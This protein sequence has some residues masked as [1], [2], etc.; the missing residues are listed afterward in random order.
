MAAEWGQ[1]IGQRA[2]KPKGRRGPRVPIPPI[3]TA[4]LR[5]R[6]ERLG[7][8]VKTLGRS[9]PPPGHPL[10]DA[11]PYSDVRVKTD[12]STSVLE[13]RPRA[14]GA[15]PRR[16][17]RADVAAP[18][19]ARHARR[20]DARHRRRGQPERAQQS[21]NRGVKQGTIVGKDGLERR[22]RPLPARPR[23]RAARAG[24]RLRAPI[25]NDRLRERDPVRR[26]AAALSLDLDVSRVGQRLLGATGKPGAF[27]AMDPRNGADRR[28]GLAARA[29]TRRC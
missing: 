14:R 26:P 12:V 10:A 19:P 2:A 13:L 25:P 8:V 28:H 29:S 4:D 1:E 7:K 9:D 27:I 22:V 23:R 20:P 6:Y 3:P 18:V 11:V 21:R 5:V 15:V 24:R 16:H 17:R